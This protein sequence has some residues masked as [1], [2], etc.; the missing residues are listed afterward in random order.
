MHYNS[1]AHHY[2]VSRSR[3]S[4]LR[5]QL[6]STWHIPTTTI[7]KANGILEQFITSHSQ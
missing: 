6:C 7:V 2:L 5:W 4:P 3:G 1:D